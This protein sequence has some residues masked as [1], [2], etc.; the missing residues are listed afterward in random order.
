[1]TIRI[2]PFGD[3]PPIYVD[4]RVWT[5]LYSHG[6]IAE[7]NGVSLLPEYES[8]FAPAALSK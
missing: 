6:K 5:K 1:M 2:L 3:N 4:P 7:V 8:I